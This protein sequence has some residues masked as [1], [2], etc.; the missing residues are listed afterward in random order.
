MIEIQSV[1]KKF[2]KGGFCL[3]PIQLKLAGG[4]T[5]ALLGQN[6]AGKT[7]LFQL[8]TG[9]DEPT[10]G[11]IFVRGE[12]VTV[13]SFQLKRTIG[14]MPQHLSLPKWVTGYEILA[15]AASL[16]ELDE[17]KPEESIRYWDCEDFKDRPLG[18]CSHG[19]QKR[20]SLALSTIHNPDLLILDE[21]F[22]GLDLFHI[23]ALE[24]LIKKRTASQL[25]TI[26]CTH[27]APYAAKLCNRAAIIKSG[28]MELISG[29]SPKEAE[30][31]TSLMESLFF[32]E[33][34]EC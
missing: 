30:K 14:Y 13:E 20:I 29:W 22:S 10:E 11:K 17:S 28:N 5:L 6:G 26:L 23:K 32:S 31:N 7:T 4:D 3:G 34:P 15:Y 19:M 2:S 27:I 21:P 8:L 9:N 24:E 33:G 16:Y 1:T 25:A 18:S 12:R